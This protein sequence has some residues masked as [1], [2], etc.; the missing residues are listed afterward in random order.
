[1]LNSEAIDQAREGAE[2]VKLGLPDSGHL[3]QVVDKSTIMKA[4][5]KSVQ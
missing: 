3:R 5:C 2:W 1:M 4:T